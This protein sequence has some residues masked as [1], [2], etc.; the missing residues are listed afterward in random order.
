MIDLHDLRERPEH[1]QQACNDKRINIDIQAFLKLD[2]DFRK[3]KSEVE[4]MRAEQNAVSREIPK[5]KSEEKDQKLA[6]MKVLSE[7]LK[8]GGQKLKELEDRWT[9]DQLRIGTIPLEGVPVGKD[10]SENRLWRTWG[11]APKPSFEVRDHVQLGKELDLFDVERG[12]KIAGA[13]S[14]FLKGDG[15]RLQHALMS[16]AMDVLY[17]AGY[18]LMDPPHIVNYAAMQG[19]SYFPGGEEMAYHLDE[20][21][22]GYYLIGTAEV[23]VASFHSDEILTLDELPKRYAGYSP[24]YRREAGAYGKD[25]AGLYRVHQ[26]YK[27]EQ[28]IICKA[29]AEESMRLHHELLGN[30]EKVMQLLELPYRIV[31]V[32]TGDMGQGQVYKHDI[33]TW[34][35]SRNSYG[36]THSCSSFY[37]FQ[38][39][40]LNTRYKDT[41]GKNVYC[42][43]LNNTC[44]ASPR[45]LIPLLE[46]H[47][48]SDGSITIPK[49]LRPYMGG[50][51]VIARKAK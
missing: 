37:D 27:V 28:V 47:Q 24:C 18:T 16:L 11:E 29:D 3:L 43:T 36:E 30:A 40:R 15:M 13:R 25:T 48:N 33:E 6:E 5:L 39:R 31:D 9:S 2:S 20:R 49:A 4:S 17:K 41:N 46:N 51:E 34:M 10:D 23:P 21:D 19:T 14:Y 12:V 35:P 22:E 42:Y 7:K 44:V 45:I 50:Q 1:Y 26:F 8:E 38:A 32:C